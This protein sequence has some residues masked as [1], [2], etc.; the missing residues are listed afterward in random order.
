MV[1]APV[2]DQ[3]NRLIGLITI[4]DAMDALE[5]ETEEDLKRLADVRN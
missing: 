1:S 2:V 4:D 5:D 3:Y